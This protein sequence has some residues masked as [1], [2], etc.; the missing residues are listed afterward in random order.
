VEGRRRGVKR[1]GEENLIKGRNKKEQMI[2]GGLNSE[3]P[4]VA[5]TCHL[6]DDLHE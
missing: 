6:I 4:K 5:N 2:N 1:G 3:G